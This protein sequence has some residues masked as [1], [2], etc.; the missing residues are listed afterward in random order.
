MA[1]EEDPRYPPTYQRVPQRM[2]MPRPR[3]L[4]PLPWWQ[5]LAGVIAGIALI[6]L[7]IL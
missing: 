1:G 4:N 5:W 2:P 3:T 6:L 7:L